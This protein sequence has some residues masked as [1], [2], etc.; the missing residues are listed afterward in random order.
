[1]SRSV[2]LQKSESRPLLI[3]FSEPLIL[4]RDD[5]LAMF[6][7]EDKVLRVKSPETCVS[8]SNPL[9]PIIDGL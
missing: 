2:K 8:D 9:K 5:K 6:E 1:M 3:M 7:R 4:L